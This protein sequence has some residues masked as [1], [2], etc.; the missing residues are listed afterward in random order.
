MCII[1]IVCIVKKTERNYIT[2][3]SITNILN[4]IFNDIET[5]RV[6]ILLYYT[7]I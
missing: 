3:I 6:I 1:T 2:V 7:R 5:R 4:D